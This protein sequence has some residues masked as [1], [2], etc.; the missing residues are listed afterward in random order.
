M[1]SKKSVIITGAGS[2]IGAATA[3]AFAAGGYNVV[4]NY[5]RNKAGADDIVEQCRAAGVDAVS[6]RG[7]IAGR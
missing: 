6:I 5:S 3:V 4:V 7:D 2:G 1:G